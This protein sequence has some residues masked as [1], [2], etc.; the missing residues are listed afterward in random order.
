MAQQQGRDITT[1]EFAKMLGVNKQTLLHYDDIGLLSPEYKSANG[2]RKYS[3]NQFELFYIIRLFNLM[4][5]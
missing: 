1:G 2:Y 5:S 3:Y 4:A